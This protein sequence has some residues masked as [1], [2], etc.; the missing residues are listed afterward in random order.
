MPERNRQTTRQREV[1]FMIDDKTGRNVYECVE[2]EVGRE[3]ARWAGPGASEAERAHR[4]DHLRVCDACRLEHA[5][6]RT[7]ATGLADGSLKLPDRTAQPRRHRL[8]PAL[9]AGAVGMAAMGLLLVILLPP[10]PPPGFGIDRSG[11]VEGFLRPVEGETVGT[12][13]TNFRWHPVPGA[14]SYRVRVEEVAGEFSWSGETDATDLALPGDVGLAAG[15]E[16][17]AYLEPVPRDLAPAGG[18]S[19][20]FRSGSLTS[21]MRYRAAA[22]PAPA[23]WLTLAGALMG[24]GAV[25]VTTLGRY[26]GQT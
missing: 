25:G 15:R 12:G 2:P 26:R 4:A 18:L 13:A 24:L 19:V 22:A 17:R 21:V 11:G 14:N 6:E 1:V 23:R 8:V 5:V 3:L 10:T 20:R 7:V 9:A 16:Y